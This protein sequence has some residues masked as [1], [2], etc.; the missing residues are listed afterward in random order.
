MMRIKSNVN[1]FLYAVLAFNNTRERNKFDYLPRLLKSLIIIYD[2]EVPDNYQKYEKNYT[3]KLHLISQK[4]KL[5]LEFSPT[6]WGRI[7]YF[8]GTTSYKKSILHR[9]LLEAFVF[10]YAKCL[11]A[12][13]Y[14]VHASCIEYQN[15]MVLFLGP[16]SAGKTSIVNKL[17]KKLGARIVS[18]NIT[19]ID[20]CSNVCIQEFS[21]V[22]T[23]QKFIEHSY[24]TKKI[25]YVLFLGKDPDKVYLRYLSKD[26][27]KNEWIA[28]H[29]CAELNYCRQL[30]QFL[31]IHPSY[32]KNRMPDAHYAK[33][34]ICHGF[35]DEGVKLIADEILS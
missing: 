20:N 28:A 15:E 24:K 19:I 11:G 21:N 4:S 33:I 16:P 13:N 34:N 35:L 7:K 26:D 22:D 12:T 10:S 18:D 25:R 14:I 30:N 29:D 6:I 1:W 31:D 23:R 27:V 32:E 5:Q 2:R 9:V 17:H 3:R 8:L